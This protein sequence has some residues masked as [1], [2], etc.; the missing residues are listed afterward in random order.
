MCRLAL[1]FRFLFLLLYINPLIPSIVTPALK[2]AT[3]RF[4][5]MLA[6]TNQST[7]RLKPEE[8][9]YYRY[10]R[11]NLKSAFHLKRNP[12]NNNVC[13]FFSHK[14]NKKNE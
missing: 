10:C 7:R 3:A 1:S 8:Y 5:E 6:C 9:H 2:M 4:S 12:N 11:E 13:K 14:R